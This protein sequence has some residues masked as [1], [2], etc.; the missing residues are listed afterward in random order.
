MRRDVT[1]YLENFHVHSFSFTSTMDIKQMLSTTNDIT[2][3]RF[4]AWQYSINGI[5]YV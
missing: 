1:S 3:I 4:L 2:G 5:R